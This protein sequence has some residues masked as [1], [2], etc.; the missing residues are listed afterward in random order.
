MWSENFKKFQNM[1]F[2]HLK[3]RT[4]LKLCTPLTTLV[5]VGMTAWWW[6]TFIF[7]WQ[8]LMEHPSSPGVN[9]TNTFTL[10]FYARRS[11]KRKNT[12]NLTVFFTH[13][14]SLRVK[15]VRR[16]LMKSTPGVNFIKVLQAAF[17]RTDPKS[18]KRYWWLNWIFYAFMIWAF[19]SC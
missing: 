11:R 15:A 18:V 6:H 3:F 7:S 5:K 2:C 4:W 12:Y 1:F 9:F 14:G 17:T 16:K 10:S 8:K 19:K 13:L